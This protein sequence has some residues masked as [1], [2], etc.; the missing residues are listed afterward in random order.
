MRWLL[1]LAAAAAL[2]GCSVDVEG[3]ACTTPGSTENCPAGQACGTG[4]TCSVAAA[5]CTPCTPGA[6]ECRDG[7]VKECSVTADPVCVTWVVKT[8]CTPGGLACAGGAQ[9]ACACPPHTESP[10]VLL[11]DPAAA[12]VAGLVRNGAATSACRFLTLGDALAGAPAGA[13]VRAA[14]YAGTPVVFTEPPLTIAAG[15]S[16]TTDD[17]TPNPANYVIEPSAAVG[18]STLVSMKPGAKLAG[19]EVRNVSASG[20]GVETSCT[21]VSDTATVTIDAVRITG[22]G[23]GTTPPP[24]FKFGVRH[25]SPG[26]CSLSMTGATIGGASDTGVLISNVAPASTLTIASSVIQG[27]QGGGT[28]FTIGPA[29]A[30]K[31]GGIAFVGA[32][33]GTVDFRANRV[34][35]N[36]GDQI[37]VF[38]TG[39]LD[40]S[41]TTCGP[42]ANVIACYAAGVGLSS[43]AGVVM[44]GFSTWS[45]P[46]PAAG[47]DYIQESGEITGL[48]QTCGFLPASSCP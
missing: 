15:V 22:L 18:T 26:Y 33:P 45:S 25:S 7:D 13:I 43:K 10:V 9:P 14:G 24:R 42:D 39:T 40:L 38:S 48:T 8:A 11:A 19:F 23:T 1:T 6:V 46:A 5:A 35:G 30:R 4:L 12:T 16:V 31:A 32:L 34:L 29:P 41:R 3:A 21:E 17:A 44:A 47:T 36:A 20:V 27:N 37:L 28:D 2:A